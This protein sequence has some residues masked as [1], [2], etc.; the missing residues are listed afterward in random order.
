MNLNYNSNNLKKKKKNF[1]KRF[2][3]HTIKIIFQR[4]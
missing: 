3:T 4:G 1:D 2:A